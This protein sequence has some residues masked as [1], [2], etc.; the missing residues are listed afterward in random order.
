[1]SNLLAL[2][3]QLSYHLLTAVL[4]VTLSHAACTV[5]A[6][7]AYQAPVLH[8]TLSGWPGVRSTLYSG[9]SVSPHLI[10]IYILL[11]FSILVRAN[12][13]R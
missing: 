10:Y 12:G 4:V 13:A 3:G 7:V 9:N 1:M 2:R 11:D 8:Q 6:G 5:S